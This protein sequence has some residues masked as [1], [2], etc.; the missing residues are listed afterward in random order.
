METAK[1]WKKRTPLFLYKP[2][3]YLRVYK[4]VTSM[5]ECRRGFALVTVFIAH[6]Q[7]VTAGN[8]SP[9]ANSHVTK[10]TTARSR[11]SVP[12]SVVVAK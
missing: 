11:T 4:F 12:S 6:V 10:F 5:S 9:V 2:I 7:A 1:G 8:Y 3:R